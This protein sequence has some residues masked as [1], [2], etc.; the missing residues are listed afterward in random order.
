MVVATLPNEAMAH[1]FIHENSSYLR[2]TKEG[3]VL[4]S[5]RGLH[6]F[7]AASFETKEEAQEYLREL[8]KEEAFKTAWIHKQ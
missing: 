5:S 4:I 6:R 3:G 7:Y 1:K 8:T 2:F